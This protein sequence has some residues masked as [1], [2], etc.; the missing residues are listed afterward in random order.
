MEEAITHDFGSSEG[1][2]VLRWEKVDNNG[3]G[4]PQVR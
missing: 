4:K 1:D 2:E 3:K